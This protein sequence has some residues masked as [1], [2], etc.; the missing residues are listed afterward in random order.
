MTKGV[1][2][3]G[4]RLRLHLVT[5]VPLFNLMTDYV[6]PVHSLIRSYCNSW[7][8]CAVDVVTKE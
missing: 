6:H 8:Q 1:D 2:S 5:R 4:L 7:L 3:G